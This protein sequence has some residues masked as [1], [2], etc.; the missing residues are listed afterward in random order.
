MD[1]HLRRACED[2]V[3]RPS[4]Y[5]DVVLHQI[6]WHEPVSALWSGL[7]RRFVGHSKGLSISKQIESGLDALAG[8]FSDSWLFRTAAWYLSYRV[9]LWNP[10]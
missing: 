3:L 1:F 7:M 6:F 9:V 2:L 5:C 10:G 4:G 8:S